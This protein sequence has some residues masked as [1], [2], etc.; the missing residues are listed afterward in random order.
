MFEKHYD[1]LEDSWLRRPRHV[2]KHMQAGLQSCTLRAY[3]VSS[4]ARVTELRLAFVVKIAALTLTLQAWS[5]LSYAKLL[6]L[7]F[8][9]DRHL[10]M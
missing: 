10:H 8:L 4:L 6:K 1:I 3:L 2:C 7:V 9:E 5:T